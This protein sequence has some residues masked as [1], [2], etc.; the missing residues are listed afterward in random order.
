MPTECNPEL[1]DFARVEGR[2]VVAAFDGGRIT[3]VLGPRVWLIGVPIMVAMF[4]WHPSPFFILFALLA[5]PLPSVGQ[6][7]IEPGWCNQHPGELPWVAVPPPTSPNPYVLTISGYAG[8][9]P[10]GG[11]AALSYFTTTGAGQGV[12]FMPRYGARTPLAPLKALPCS[13]ADPRDCQF[14]HDSG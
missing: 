7:K 4:L 3:A 12:Y 14:E 1:F 6:V 8:N 5:A 13:A 9:N 11:P 2:A 10:A